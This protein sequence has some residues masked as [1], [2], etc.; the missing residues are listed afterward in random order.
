[1][2]CDLCCVL[3]DVTP[4]IFLYTH[5]YIDGNIIHCTGFEMETVENIINR[6]I[7]GPRFPVKFKPIRVAHIPYI[8]SSVFT[9]GL[10]V[11]RLF[12]PIA[13]GT[14]W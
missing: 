1:M 11:G 8:N 12:H 9:G 7:Y 5:T 6:A 4:F 13:R 14:P 3:I 10:R 2:V